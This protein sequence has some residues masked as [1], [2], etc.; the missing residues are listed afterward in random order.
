MGASTRCPYGCES[1]NA[2]TLARK[3]ITFENRCLRRIMNT[4]WKDFKFHE[5]LRKETKQAYVTDVIRKRVGHSSATLSECTKT[6]FHT[7][8]SPRS[9]NARHKRISARSTKMESYDFCPM[10]HSW[11]GRKLNLTIFPLCLIAQKGS[12]Y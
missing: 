1:W 5:R 11:H 10:C 6:E 9:E 7:R 12:F 8:Y 2:I 3:L 4:S